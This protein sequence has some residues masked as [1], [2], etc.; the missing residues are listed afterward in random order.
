M[1]TKELKNQLQKLITNKVFHAA[2]VWGAPGIGKSSILKQLADSNDLDFI[3]LRISQIVPTDLRGLPVAK[4]DHFEYLRPDFLPKPGAKPGILLLDE[5]NQAPPSVQAIVQQLILDRKVGSY[6]IPDGWFIWGGG[7][8]KEDKTAVYDMPAAV[9]NRFLH[10]EVEIDYET[11]KQ[12]YALANV[13][14]QIVAFLGFRPELL[15]KFDPTAKAW[16][17]P[18]SWA[19]ASSLHS[20]GLPILSAVGA[21]ATGEFETYLEVYTKLPDLTAILAGKGERIAWPA[22]I[23]VKFATSV[24]LLT[25]AIPA[26]GPELVNILNWVMDKAEPEWQHKVFSDLINNAKRLTSTAAL[27][28]EITSNPKINAVLSNLLALSS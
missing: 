27:Y 2:M 1:N 22:E 15:H 14:E 19:M 7:N 9:A 12:D 24:G 17:S 28:K 18:R 13:H 21:A 3:D 5:A 26:G 4:E 8:R 23:S 16:P 6:T 25:R 20:I 11:W 10:F